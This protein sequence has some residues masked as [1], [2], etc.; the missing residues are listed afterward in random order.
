MI[1]MCKKKT[2][3]NHADENFALFSLHN[4][5]VWRYSFQISEDSDRKLLIRN[6]VL[7]EEKIY[8]ISRR[9]ENSRVALQ[10][11]VS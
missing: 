8:D 10:S 6:R 1:V 5:S 3:T 7:I 11:D 4:M 2:H 9:L